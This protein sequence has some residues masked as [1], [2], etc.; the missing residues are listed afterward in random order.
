MFL[1]GFPVMG[2]LITARTVR[3]CAIGGGMTTILPVLLLS[4]FSLTSGNKIFSIGA[5]AWLLGLFLLG[6][7]G[8]LL[9][10][11]IAFRGARQGSNMSERC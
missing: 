2:V 3:G 11:L 7:L 4:I 8:G 1:I 5:M 9:F 10:Y 6:C